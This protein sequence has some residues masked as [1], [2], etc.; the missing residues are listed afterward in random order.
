MELDKEMRTPRRLSP[1]PTFLSTLLLQQ[2]L[3]LEEELEKYLK[4][5]KLDSEMD[6]K[7][8]GVAETKIPR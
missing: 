2:W 1:W 8:T 5:E 6:D 4:G 3:L 7:L